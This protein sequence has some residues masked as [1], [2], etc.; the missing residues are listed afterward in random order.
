M[1]GN[2]SSYLEFIGAVYFS[3]SL[4]EILTKKVW[5]PQDIKKQEKALFGLG[6]NKDKEFQKAVLEANRLKGETLQAELSKKSIIGLF[7]VAFL[8][9][10]CG[11]ESYIEE[12]HKEE[13]FTL[14]LELAYI[15]T[16][17]LLSLFFLQWVIFSKW[18]YATLFIGGMVLAFLLL[19]ICA[20]VYGQTCLEIFIVEHIGLFTCIVISIPILWQIFITWIYKSVFYGFI[21]N[22]ISIAEKMYQKVQKDLKE[23]HFDKLPKGYYEIYIR[24]SQKILI[25]RQNKCWTILLQSIREFCI[26]KYVL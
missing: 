16:L 12:S 11:Y 4:D 1:V 20:I 9:I 13:L 8:L 23:G 17:Y 18:K 3:M 22:K 5:S 19:R 25:Q 10:F 26:M 2:Y 15:L 21:K 24:N 7:I 14:H 6:M